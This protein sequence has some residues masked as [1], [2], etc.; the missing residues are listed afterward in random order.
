MYQIQYDNH[1]V[2]IVYSLLFQIDSD[3][4]KK[5]ML[6]IVI[7]VYIYEILTYFKFYLGIVK[8]IV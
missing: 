7:I 3:F 2:N 1:G 5:L 8:L 6:F 4:Y